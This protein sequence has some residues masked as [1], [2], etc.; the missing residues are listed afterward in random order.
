[1]KIIRFTVVDSSKPHFGVV[2]GDRAVAFS[3]LQG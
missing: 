3:V 1:M 2:I